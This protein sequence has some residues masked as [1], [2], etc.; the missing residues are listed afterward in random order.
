MTVKKKILWLVVSCLM[1][2]SLVIASC[3]PAEEEAEV[4]MGE[5]EVEVGE[6]EVE[7]GEEEVVEE[8]GLLPPDVP[9]YGGTYT[10]IAF[11]DYRNW[12]P[13]FGFPMDCT[14]QHFL[15]GYPLQGD[16]TKGLAGT[17]EIEWYGGF[18]GRSDV[19][20]GNFCE[21]WEFPDNE[22]IIW[23]VRQGVYYHDKYPVNGRQM[24]AY[25]FE[26]CMTRTW[27]PPAYHPGSVDPD[28][29]PTSIT[30]TDKWTCVM[31]VP[32]KQ[33]GVVW[34][35][36]G[37]MSWIYPR[38]VIDVYGDMKDWRN[39]VGA[40]PFILTDYVTGSSLTYIKNPN[41]WQHDPFHPENQL[42]YIDTLRSLIIADP[43]TRLAALRTAK[44]D[45][46]T[47]IS[48]EDAEL[49]LKQCPD[50]MY[51]TGYGMSGQPCMRV[52]TPSLPTY[53]IRVRQALN[54]AINKQEIIDDYY[55][56]HA[57]MLGWPYRPEKAYAPWW[58]PLEEQPEAVQM[59][60]EYDTTKA[61][62]LLADAGYPNGFNCKIQCMSTD[63]DF[64]A[65]IQ[66]Y[67]ED[68]DVYMEIEPAEASIYYSY[69]RGRKHDDMLFKG[70]TTH[71]PARMLDSR[72]ESLD[73]HAF[74]ET[75]YTRETYNTCCANYWD[76]TITTPL[77]KEYGSYILEQAIGIWL[78]VPVDYHMWWPWVQNYHGEQNMGFVQGDYYV[79][80]IWVDEALKASMG[81]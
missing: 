9:K 70:W 16:W 57:I 48:W 68:I 51:R 31:K 67:L 58:T 25:D 5:E 77:L 14:A 13:G 7:V 22:T 74:F 6:E 33:M 2:L 43:S 55:E 81:H 61:K 47:G 26:Y 59:L 75:T 60:F 62:Q 24:D 79:Y 52:D 34:L 63:A 65:L 64:L 30:A 50:L 45:K 69:Y 4:E 23:H 54:M 17:G 44:V 46:H 76:D 27:T 49:L 20:T 42:P 37:G 1:A 39:Q 21:S 29:S 53:D 72:M 41:Y 12:D 66:N 36:T 80:Y 3:G 35:L 19:F 28:A 18:S 78:P 10:F 73:N 15:G 11:S 56:G 40:G 8:E 71:W 32:A 38:E